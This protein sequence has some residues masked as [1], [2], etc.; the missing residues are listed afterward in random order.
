MY[1]YIQECVYIYIFIFICFYSCIYIIKY[2]TPITS[3]KGLENPAKKEK[4]AAS[5]QPYAL[6][7][8]KRAADW[9]PRKERL[10]VECLGLGFT[11]KPKP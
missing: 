5:E 11:L 3:L 1:I 4:G 10:R 6:R 7:R 2:V 9:V 8:A